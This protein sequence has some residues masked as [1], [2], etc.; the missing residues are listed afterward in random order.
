MNEDDFENLED[1]GVSVQSQESLEND[2]IEKLEEKIKEKEQE[3]V[4]KQVKKELRALHDRLVDCI[5]KKRKCE[6]QIKSLYQS[7]SLTSQQN[8]QVSSLLNDQEILEKKLKDLFTDQNAAVQRLKDCQYDYE[9]NQDIQ[10]LIVRS[11]ESSEDTN[12]EHHIKDEE[13]ELQKNIRLGDVTAFGNTLQTKSSSSSEPVNFDNYLHQQLQNQGTS[14][15]RTIN[16]KRHHSSD[17][18]S[19]SGFV[20]VPVPKKTKK[21]AKPV[22]KDED[23][24]D[25]KPESSD[26]D[27]PLIKKKEVKKSSKPQR[28]LYDSDEVGFKTDDSDWEGTDDDDDEVPVIKKRKHGD[29]GDRDMYLARVASWQANRSAEDR[30]SD[31]RYEEVE[32]GLKVPSSLWEKLYNYQKIGVQWMFELHQQKCGGILGDEMGLGKT[33]QVISFLAS[34]SYSQVDI[35]IG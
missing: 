3:N 4:L 14:S 29:D 34:L 20:E 5:K 22:V 16:R 25:Y 21:P 1:L 12:E 31:G 26:D 24:S 35:M 8:R 19:D 9:N 2:V 17:S 32:G 7:E 6:K 33:I 23:D 15:S 10:R 11:N 28:P 30:E 13:T 27:E 18:G